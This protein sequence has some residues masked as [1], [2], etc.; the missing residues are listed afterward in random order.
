MKL[1]TS[2]L[3]K[4]IKE[5]L[6]KG[7]P[8]FAFGTIAQNVADVASEEFVKVLIAHINTSSNDSSI[9]NKRYKAAS[10]TGEMIKR[11]LEF[12]KVIEDKLKEKL[13]V[14]LDNSR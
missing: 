9:R 2:A 13:L 12:K 14:F 1:S 11:D 8:D 7:I 10:T 5:E 6:A 3:R 4:L